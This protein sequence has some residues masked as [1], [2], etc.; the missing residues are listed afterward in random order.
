[1]SLTKRV[2]GIRVEWFFIASDFQL[3]K[4]KAPL[5]SRNADERPD[6]AVKND[7]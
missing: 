3:K 1:M 6:K 2:D 5:S 4:K 7:H